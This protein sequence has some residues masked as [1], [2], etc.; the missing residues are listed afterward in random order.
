[1]S[2]PQPDPWRDLRSLR[3]RDWTPRSNLRVARTPLARPAFPTVDVHAHLGRAGRSAE[4]SVDDVPALVRRMDDLNLTALVNLDGRAGEELSANLARYDRAHPGRFVTFCNLDWSEFRTGTPVERQIE[5]LED[6][7]RRGA[8]G[9]KVFKSLGLE[10][11]DETGRLILPDDHRVIRIM[12]RAGEL[13]LPVLIHVADPRAFF[14]PLDHENERLDELLV[15]PTW[16]FGDSA[17]YPSFD[18]LMAALDVLLGSCPSTS[19][20]GAHCGTAEDLDAVERLLTRHRNYAIDIAGRLAELGRQPRR[21][22]RLVADFPDRILF[23]TDG[24]PPTAA[25]L[26]TCVRF[27][28]TE[29]E[30]FDYDPESVIPPSGRWQI[31]GAGLP[32]H[33]LARVYSENARTI[34]GLP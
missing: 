23:G 6:C 25:E 10:H 30:S 21:F 20:I 34:V 3:L 2:S 17:V 27:L 9:L 11:R 7:A 14:T 16:W 19:F 18:R 12:R 32:P 31:S 8:R 33:H 26:L 13:G 1:M 22:A 4:W 15:H 5:T 28:E 24:A 29:D